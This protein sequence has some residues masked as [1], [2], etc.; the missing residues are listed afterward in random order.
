MHQKEVDPSGIWKSDMFAICVDNVVIQSLAWVESVKLVFDEND[1]SFV[2]DHRVGGGVNIGP[3]LV[4][5]KM[6]S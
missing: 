3:V 5:K 6:D 2:H 4:D 1:V